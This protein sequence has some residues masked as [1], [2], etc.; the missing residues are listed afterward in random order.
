MGPQLMD[1]DTSQHSPVSPSQHSAPLLHVSVFDLA[2]IT[3]APST[4]TSDQRHSVSTKL[5]QLQPEPDAW[6]WPG[7]QWPVVQLPRSTQV[8]VAL[9]RSSYWHSAAG[10]VPQ[11]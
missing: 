9:Q 2:C 10:G 1:S 5:P 11:G 4:Q 7:G 3:Q 8:P 6:S